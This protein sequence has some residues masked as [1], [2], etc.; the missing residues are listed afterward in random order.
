MD[1]EGDEAVQVTE[2]SGFQLLE[3]VL[4][5]VQQLDTLEPTEDTCCQRAEVVA[6]ELERLQK[7]GLVEEALRDL[8]V[9]VS[10]L[11]NFQVRKPCSKNVKTIV[12]LCLAFLK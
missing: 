11:Q 3:V 1:I 9:R 7:T 4:P 8:D 12:N 5:E 6:A 2:H 10:Q